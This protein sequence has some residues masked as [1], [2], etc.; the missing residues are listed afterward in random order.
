MLYNNYICAG[1]L[2]PVYQLVFMTKS[3][4]SMGLHRR[5]AIANMAHSLHK[6]FFFQNIHKRQP[7]AQPCGW[8]S[9]VSFCRKHT[10]SR[11]Y[12]VM[13][14]FL[15]DHGLLV[16]L[17]LSQIAKLMGPTWGPPGSCRPQMGPILAPW[18]LLS[19]MFVVGSPTHRGYRLDGM[20]YY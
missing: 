15:R 20:P 18:T 11:S 6:S 1:C 3:G 17:V 7:I 10:S 4:H 14:G 19:G 16:M 8:A 9:V 13:M 2:S 5:D 12:Y